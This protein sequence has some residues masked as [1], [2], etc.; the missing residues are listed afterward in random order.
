MYY[1]YRQN[2]VQSLPPLP[3]GMIIKKQTPNKFV[4]KMHSMQMGRK[5]F[6][7]FSV[8]TFLFRGFSRVFKEYDIII[9]NE[10]ISKAVLISKVPIYKFLPKDGIHLCYCETIPEARG[11]GYYPLLL[12]YIQNDMPK[13]NLYMI[14][15]VTNSASIRGIEKAGFVRYAMG[16][17]MSNGYFVEK[18][19]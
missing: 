19:M 3:E 2:Q 17:K 9:N 13:K 4:P 18:K 10:I 6:Y 12:N 7:Y 8:M 5:R 16:E 1:F 11:K 14:V 15:D